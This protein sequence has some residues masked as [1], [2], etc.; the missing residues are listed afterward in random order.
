MTYTYYGYPEDFL[1]VYQ[2]AVTKVTKQDVLR[3]VK[4]YYKPELLTIVAVGN[5]KNIGVPLS[6][7]NLPVKQ[8]DV[9]IPGDPK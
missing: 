7:L 4:Q 9:S 3:V 8:L 6:S 2:E 5:Q 1:R